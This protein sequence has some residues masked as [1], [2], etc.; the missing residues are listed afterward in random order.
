[1]REQLMQT[2]YMFGVFVGGLLLGMMK[3]VRRKS[4]EN[5]PHLTIERLHRSD[6]LIH[7]HL[8]RLMTLLGPQCIRAY[9]SK[10]HNGERYI[11]DS[12]ILKKSRTHEVV[13][14]GVSYQADHYKGMLVSIMPDE[15]QLAIEPGNSFRLVRELPPGRFKSLCVIGGVEAIARAAVYKD[16]DIVGFI[17]VDFRMIDGCECPPSN[18]QE[19]VNCAARIS[20]LIP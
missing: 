8:A 7:E 18:I 19:I 10:F 1:M 14:D 9:L 5:H 2:G 4:K 6:L 13:A 15:M 16:K 17:G 12:D 20:S 11:D 3:A